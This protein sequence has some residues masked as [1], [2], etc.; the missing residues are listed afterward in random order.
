M[1]ASLDDI[2]QL[3][4]GKLVEVDIQGMFRLHTKSSSRHVGDGTEAG[5]QRTFDGVRGYVRRCWNCGE[6]GHLSKDCRQPRRESSY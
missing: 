2:R 1:T 3:V 6:T 4:E 5:P